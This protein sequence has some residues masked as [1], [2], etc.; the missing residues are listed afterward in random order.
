MQLN[1]E[2]NLEHQALTDHQE[3]ERLLEMVRP[4]CQALTAQWH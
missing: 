3:A 1:G 2:I 4:D